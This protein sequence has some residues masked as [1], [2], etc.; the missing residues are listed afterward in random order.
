MSYI[1]K[2]RIEQLDK[3]EIGETIFIYNSF[4]FQ[5]GTIIEIDKDVY[6]W[7]KIKTDGK[8]LFD[9]EEHDEYQQVSDIVYMSDCHRDGEYRYSNVPKC[10]ATFYTKNTLYLVIDEI[11]ISLKH[12]ENEIIKYNN[13]LEKIN[14]E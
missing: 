13:L 12:H 2:Y 6:N 1:N 4:N 10:S 3:V 9:V 5:K 11:K 14:L 7:Y 8:S